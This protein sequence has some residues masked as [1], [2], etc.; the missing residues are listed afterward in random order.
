MLW[1]SLL[2]LCLLTSIFFQSC[3]R[4]IGVEGITYFWS[5]KRLWK[6][7]HT[8]R[9][10]HAVVGS[11]GLCTSSS[12]TLEL[13]LQSYSIGPFNSFTLLLLGF[14]SLILTTAME[15]NRCLLTSSDK[16]RIGWKIGSED[17]AWYLC[18]QYCC[19]LIYFCSSSWF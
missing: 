11:F 7:N 6:L 3:F 16:Y 14:G 12:C 10:Q 9:N 19:R 5:S 2:L 17:S 18:L 4:V 8:G 15:D 13:I 1:F